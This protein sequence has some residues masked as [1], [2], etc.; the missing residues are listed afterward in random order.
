MVNLDGCNETCNAPDDLLSRMCNPSKTKNIN[1]V[2]F[3]MTPAISESKTFAKQILSEW[4]Q[5]YNG[6]K[7]NLNQKWDTNEC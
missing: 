6:K 3:N 2:V 5:K 7:C 4:K 1:L